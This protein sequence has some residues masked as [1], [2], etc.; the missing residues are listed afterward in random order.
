MPRASEGARLK[1]LGPDNKH[2]AKP[3]RGFSRYVWYIM[4]RVAGK[5]VERS[6]GIEFRSN[7]L[8]GRDAAEKALGDYIARKNLTQKPAGPADPE[9]MRI[10]D[11]LTIYAEEH[12]A[13]HVKDPER[14]GYAIDRLLEFWGNKT[15][16]DITKGSRRQYAEQRIVERRAPK[17]GEIVVVGRAESST[18]RRELGTLDA[19]CRYAVG[20]KRLKFFPD[21]QW[22][23][24]K[25]EAR[26]RWLTRSEAAALLWAI[27]KQRKAQHLAL[28]VL[29]GLYMGARRESI[30]SLQWASN[31]EGGW[32]DLS[33]GHIDFLPQG[34]AQSIK[35]R[36]ISP[37][38]N[39]L[40]RFLRYAR[41]KT[42]RYVIETERPETL[43]DG[44]T[45]LALGRVQSVKRSFATACIEAGLCDEV[46]DAQGRI[47]NGDDGNPLLEPNATPHTLKHTCI[48][49]LLQDGVDP[50]QVAGFVRTSLETIT[51]VYGHHCPNRMQDAK[52]AR[53]GRG[54]EPPLSQRQS[55]DVVR[56]QA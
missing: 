53:R 48:T 50:W 43:P 13:K 40:L 49:W 35:Q 5:E 44:R 22:L 3:R 4:D 42:R 6:T 55:A 51:R 10:A 16:D 2:G 27:R 14:I 46:T 26:Q 54:A 17:T 45:V 36:A 12:A 25:A 56:L 31:A 32:V 28:F 52:E 39:R 9:A 47:V 33:Q 30:L 29:I 7:S 19:A 34:A 15:V 21:D 1:L 20:E 23:P 37:I 18:V 38:P 41:Q 11:V 8:S 24:H